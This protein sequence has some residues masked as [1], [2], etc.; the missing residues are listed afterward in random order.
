MLLLSLTFT[1]AYDDIEDD[2]DE[3]PNDMPWEDTPIATHM[4]QLVS[5]GNID[6]LNSLY[7]QNQ[8]W[9]H[10]RSADGRGGLFWAY[11]YG[12][13]TVVSMFLNAGVNPEATDMDGKTPKEMAPPGFKHTLDPEAKFVYT[14]PPTYDEDDEDEEANPTLYDD[15]DDDEF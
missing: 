10:L 11:E 15:V 7:S 8:K 2:E 6:G 14:A 12:Q 1:S 9:V 5:T 3:D 4:W 13:P